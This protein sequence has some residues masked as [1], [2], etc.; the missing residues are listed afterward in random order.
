VR[1]RARRGE[2]RAA[3]DE[4]ARWRLADDPLDDRGEL[5]AASEPLREGEAR[6][7]LKHLSRHLAANRETSEEIVA[8]RMR[9]HRPGRLARNDRCP[10][11]T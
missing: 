2:S 10:E 1:E 6:D 4:L 11:H 8:I 3:R 9:A 5:V 7:F